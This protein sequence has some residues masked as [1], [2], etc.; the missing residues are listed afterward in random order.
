M[1]TQVTTASKTGN[2]SFDVAQNAAQT[3]FDELDTDR[4]DFC[5]VFVSSKYEY[6]D[7]LNGIRSVIGDTPELIGCSSSGE[8][9]EDG[10][11]D[12]SVTIALVTSDN[13]KFYTDLGTG[14]DESVMAAV[15]EATTDLPSSVDGYPHLSAINLHD[16]LAG[17]GEQ[18]A[19]TTQRKLGQQVS[20]VGGSAG[21]DLQMEST[22]VFCNDVVAENAVSIALI[23][24]KNPFPITSNHGHEPVSDPITATKVEDNVIHEIDGE[25]AF[26][27]WKD[28]VRDLVK[29]QHGINVDSLEPGSDEFAKI[30]NEYEFGIDQGDTYKIRWPG[31]TTTDDGP[32]TFAVNIPED[33]V[34]H[35]MHSPPQEQIESA[36]DAAKEAKDIAGDTEIAGA[37]VYDCVCRAAILGSE[38]DDAVDA[39]DT[40]L[41]VPLQGFETYGELCMQMGQ[42]SGFHNTTSVI[43]LL[44]E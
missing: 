12:H 31:L 39:I 34:M 41:D 24:S 18:L 5:Q 20:F 27:V 21:D 3:A 9:T 13:L 11:V 19:L 23:A 43:M 40:E 29:E 6:Q 7:T 14:L 33:S 35:V 1:E 32:I 42:M 22:H 30:L 10:V 26:D 38:F 28:Q 15:R 2:D 4:V 36:R 16:G 25:P 8:F 17:V 44:P 37:F